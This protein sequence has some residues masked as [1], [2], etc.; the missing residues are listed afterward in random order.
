[1]VE[2]ASG[3]TGELCGHG[4]WGVTSK[5]WRDEGFRERG[6]KAKAVEGESGWNREGGPSCESIRGR[7]L[8]TIKNQGLTPRAPSS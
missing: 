4:Q 1:M 2:R 8:T 5:N 3:E 7:I 6:G